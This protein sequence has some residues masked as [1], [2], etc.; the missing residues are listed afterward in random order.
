MP[1]QHAK[2]LRGKF[3]INAAL[4][5]ALTLGVAGLGLWVSVSLGGALETNHIVATALQNH[6]YADMMHD[7]LR[8][9]VLAALETGA[10]ADAA[11]KQTVR[12]DAAEHIAEFRKSVDENEALDLPAS[13]QSVITAI[14]APM[15]DYLVLA[16]QMVNLALD[17]P[18]AARGRLPEFSAKFRLLED[19]MGNA[20]DQILEIVAKAN[21]KSAQ[22]ERFGLILMLAAAAAGLGLTLLVNVLTGR[23]VV[24]PLNAMTGAMT[25]LADGTLNIDIP[26]QDRRDEIGRMAAAV[27]VFK[28]NAIERARLESESAAANEQR[29]RRVTEINTLSSNF[30]Q[31]IRA[32]LQQLT[33]STTALDKTANTMTDVAERTSERA[34]TVASTANYT[35]ENTNTVASATGELTSSIN[36]IG[37]QVAQSAGASRA[38][39]EQAAKTNEI[40][41]SMADAAEKIGDVVNLIADIAAQTNLLALNAT[42]E[43]ARAGEAGKGFAVVA[44]EVKNLA[45]QTAKATEEITAQIGAVQD[46]SRASLEAIKMIG[47]T[48]TKLDEI[49]GSVAAALEEQQAA[50]QEIARNVSEAA[51]GAGEIAAIISEVTSAAQETHGA[52]RMVLQASHDLSGQNTG[53]RQEIDRFLEDVKAA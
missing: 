15:A 33:A 16:E 1:N 46:A 43:A 48:I 47:E 8:S 7:A 5:G 45:S 53:L 49:N 35:R 30:E 2:S 37:R 28:E 31:K 29:Q 22:Q 3:F 13:T 24:P 19:A 17:T 25:A 18:D 10:H 23:A 38:A 39:V 32:V 12:D 27:R 14:E 11:A 26:G 9:D 36:E 4:T 20:S 6:T 51:T 50:T 34:A 41:S 42:I 52:G 40:V 21:E 44:S